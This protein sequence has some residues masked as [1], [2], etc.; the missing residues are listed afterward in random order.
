MLVKGRIHSY[1]NAFPKNS[2]DPVTVEGQGLHIALVPKYI[3][4]VTHSFQTD[5]NNQNSLWS[6]ATFYSFNA[7]NDISFDMK[8][9]FQLKIR[10]EE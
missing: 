2:Y 9:H 1:Q 10:I 6:Q 7:T 5:K 8:K 4:K 3:G